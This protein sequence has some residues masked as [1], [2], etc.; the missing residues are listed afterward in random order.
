MISLLLVCKKLYFDMMGNLIDTCKKSFISN[1]SSR[2][3]K[4]YLL[5]SRTT[6]SYKKRKGS[7]FYIEIFQNVRKSVRM[8]HKH[9]YGLNLRL[10][11]KLTQNNAQ[12]IA[13]LMY[14][15]SNIVLFNRAA[16]DMLIMNTLL[17]FVFKFYITYSQEYQFL[18]F[19][20]VFFFFF[21]S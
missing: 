2:R 13:G 20:F 21:Y 12:Y 11:I 4:K 3:K 14:K 1:Y 7:S 19:C 8:Y 5:S 10:V 15:G 9:S 6:Q 18:F 17:D 16:I